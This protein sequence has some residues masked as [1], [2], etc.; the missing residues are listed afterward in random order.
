VNQP[1]QQQLQSIFGGDYLYQ[2]IGESYVHGLMDGE[3]YANFEECDDG[4]LET[5][6]IM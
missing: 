3:A 4:D 5:F 2:L 6:V 1:S